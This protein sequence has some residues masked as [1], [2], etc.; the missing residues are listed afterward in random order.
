MKNRLLAT[1]ER[2]VAELRDAIDAIVRDDYEEAADHFA[3]ARDQLTE[4]AAELHPDT[5]QSRRD[6]REERPDDSDNEG[7]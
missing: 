1:L 2:I 3:S 4:K 6:S 7:A 5:E